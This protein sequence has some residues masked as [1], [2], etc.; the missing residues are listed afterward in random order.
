MM[1]AED[2]DGYCFSKWLALLMGL[3]MTWTKL[4]KDLKGQKV[5]FLF[6]YEERIWYIAALLD[7]FTP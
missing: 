1:Y 6:F 3:Q 4:K 5:P 2:E 7:T